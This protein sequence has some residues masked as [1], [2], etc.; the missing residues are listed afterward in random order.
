MAAQP[1][2]TELD[3]AGRNS[4]RASA[5]ACRRGG[6]LHACDRLVRTRTCISVPLLALDAS[7]AVRAR[8]SLRLQAKA[9]WTWPPTAALETRERVL[10]CG[11]SDRTYEGNVRRGRPRFS[12]LLPRRSPPPISL[13]TQRARPQAVAPATSSPGRRRDI[14]GS[15]CHVR[16]TA[17]VAVFFWNRWIGRNA[18]PLILHFSQAV[19]CAHVP[20]ISCCRCIARHGELALVPSSRPRFLHVLYMQWRDGHRDLVNLFHYSLH[21]VRRSS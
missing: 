21:A 14:V 16:V 4:T 20:G 7:S 18:C 9:F 1:G 15:H 12:G 11:D 6:L 19:E 5:V 3:G 10:H 8:S 2:S 17:C 13:G